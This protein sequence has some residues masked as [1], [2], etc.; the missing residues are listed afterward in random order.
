MSKYSI[1]YAVL[2]SGSDGNAYIIENQLGSILIDNGYNHK[3]FYKRL[4]TAGFEIEKLHT[5][6]LTH[7]HKDHSGYVFSLA[8]ELGVEVVLHQ[9]T[10]IKDSLLSKDRLWHVK[11]DRNYSKTNKELYF[12]PF[13][14]SHDCK[15]SLGYSIQLSSTRFTII[16]DTGRTSSTMKD[17]AETS[18]VL[19]LEANYSEQMLLE[20]SYPDHL[21]ARILGAKGHLSNKE[22][23]N[24]LNSLDKTKLDKIYFCHLSK[25][26]N[27][28]ETAK[29]EIN[30][31]VKLNDKMIFCPHDGQMPT[32][33]VANNIFT[34][35][36][37][38]NFN[39]P[40]CL[41]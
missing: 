26:N 8:K 11:P 17:L 3:K 25:N 9:N 18:D 28:V 6:F 2:G 34:E 7:M 41:L 37:Y 16:T 33:T 1:R 22:S 10:D 19:F 20:G 13:S 14:T 23:A 27:S 36:I 35:K 40:L 4:T 24:F 30:E 12:T 32:E 38:Y 31:I 5:I 21:K 39:L 29:I 15:H